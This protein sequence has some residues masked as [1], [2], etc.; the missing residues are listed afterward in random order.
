M[1]ELS[2][3]LFPDFLICLLNYSLRT[4][5]YVPA[6]CLAWRPDELVQEGRC[7]HKSQNNQ[8][9]F[10]P[11][12][13]DCSVPVHPL[14]GMYL[15]GNSSAFKLFL[16][17]SSDVS[18]CP[19]QRCLHGLLFCFTQLFLATHVTSLMVRGGKEPPPP[20]FISWLTSEDT[21]DS[22]N[23]LGPHLGHGGWSERD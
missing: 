14:P 23:S 11:E 8:T 16:V 10:F 17:Q 22:V 13:V 19:H 3:I 1:A 4:E 20:W 15:E 5:V 12:I 6:T 9:V 2:F 7:E 18:V 21:Q